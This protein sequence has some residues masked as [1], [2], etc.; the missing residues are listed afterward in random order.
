M[1]KKL[2]SLIVL[3]VFILFEFCGLY[4]YALTPYEGTVENP[5]LQEAT[6]NSITLVPI[7]GYEYSI[8]GQN[9]QD[10][11]VF[12]GLTSNTEYT[13]YQ[14]IKETND[15]YASPNSDKLVVKTLAKNQPII[16]ELP[17]LIGVSDDFIVVAYKDGYE[18]SIDGHTWQDNSVFNDLSPATNYV[19]FQ[20]MKE[21]DTS[22]PSNATYLNVTTTKKRASN[23]KPVEIINITTNSVELKYYDGYEYSKD[24]ND[25]TDNWFFGGLEPGHDYVFYQRIKETYDTY[26]SKAVS[27]NV[28]TEKYT[29]ENP[30]KPIVEEIS[31]NRVVIR[32]H[33]CYQ[34]S[35]DGVTF[36]YSEIF[37]GLTPNTEYTFYQ[38]R[39]ETQDTYASPISEPLIV[40]TPKNTAG[41]PVEPEKQ[42]VTCS[43]IVLKEIEG[44][45]YSIDGTNF[46]DD[47]KFEGLNPNTEY[48]LYQRIKE[49]NDTYASES[50]SITIKTLKIEVGDINGDGKVNITD[51]ALINAHVKKTKLLTGEELA[52]A[53]IND[54]GKINITDVALLNA[55]VKKVKLLF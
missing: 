28:K 39:F 49:T 35:K 14:R 2:T 37:E 30:G 42:V 21:T 22:Y 53:D 32:P 23:P 24:G 12:E 6:I 48:I 45:E 11:N 16:T 47:N 50:S 10:S 44:Y 13:F 33:F 36:Q 20:R 31:S 40:I 8:D 43:S 46:Q 34:Y 4:S 9:Y 52:R 19:V 55:H 29:P 51:V 18:F 41:S 7:E 1:L 26:A 15:N 27:L 3:I 5:A 38:R 54:D 25:Y 17:Y